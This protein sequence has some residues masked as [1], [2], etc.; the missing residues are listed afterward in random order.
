MQQVVS[1]LHSPGP[2]NPGVAAALRARLGCVAWACKV[3]PQEAL[4]LRLCVL[5]AAVMR[6]LIIGCFLGESQSL[7]LLLG[8][9][10]CRSLACCDWV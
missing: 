4:L 8:G 10:S 9:W 6:G 2:A 3:D 5:T 1:H 7:Q